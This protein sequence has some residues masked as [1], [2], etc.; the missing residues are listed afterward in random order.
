MPPLGT[1]SQPAR[2]GTYVGTG[3]ADYP[4]N[5]GHDGYVVWPASMPTGQPQM[6]IAI[7]RVVTVAAGSATTF[8]LNSAVFGGTGGT[9]HVFRHGGIDAMFIPD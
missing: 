3:P 2:I 7:R 1:S 5:Y 9:G 8:Y 4:G 6:G